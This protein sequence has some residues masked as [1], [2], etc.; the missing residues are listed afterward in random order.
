MPLTNGGSLN[1]AAD[2]TLTFDG[3]PVEKK[4]LGWAVR[5]AANNDKSVRIVICSAENVPP[6]ELSDLVERVKDT[7]IKFSVV[8]QSGPTSD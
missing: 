1:L 6:A 4:A 2:S 8:P 5:S 3:L 7:G